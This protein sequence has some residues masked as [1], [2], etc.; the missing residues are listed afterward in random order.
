MLIMFLGRMDRKVRYFTPFSAIAPFI[1][2]IRPLSKVC[3]ND[4][5]AGQAKAKKKKVYHH[6][7]I[8]VP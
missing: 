4:D 8:C 1:N 7:R 6:A 2:G 3:D 5:S